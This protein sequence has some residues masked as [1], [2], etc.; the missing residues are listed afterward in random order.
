MNSIKYKKIHFWL[1][2]IVAFLISA[3]MVSLSWSQH[4]HHHFHCRISGIAQNASADAYFRLEANATMLEYT[5]EVNNIENIT[6]AHIHLG[7]PGDINTPVVWLYPPSPPPKPIPG[8]FSGVLAEGTITAKDFIGP[9]R[10]EPLSALLGHMQK[11]HAFVNI[12]TQDHPQGAICG[13]VRLLGD[14]KPLQK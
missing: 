12:H 4:T 10:G 1:I 7:L 13:Q 3:G 5:L 6:M 2:M 11:D 8:S 14:E 9:L